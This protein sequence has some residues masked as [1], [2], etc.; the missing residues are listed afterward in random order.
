L[1]IFV[2]SVSSVTILALT[3]PSVSGNDDVTL[4]VRQS[5]KREV[6]FDPGAAEESEDDV[7]FFD[8]DTGK[9]DHLLAKKLAADSTK[10]NLGEKP[11]A[12][13]A[14]P[15]PNFEEEP[16][17]EM[18][19]VPP[20][21]P[22][23][24]AREPGREQEGRWLPEAKGNQPE[25]E[26]AENMHEQSV[27]VVGTNTRDEEEEPTLPPV[28]LDKE[29]DQTQASDED[30]VGPSMDFV[31][32]A[33]R[34]LAEKELTDSELKRLSPKIALM[35]IL[36]NDLPPRHD[37]QQT[38][39]NVRYILENEP[40]FPNTRKVWVFNRI[41]SEEKIA[42]LR[43]LIEA[44]PG[45]EILTIPFRPDDYARQDYDFNS[46][47]TPNYVFVKGWSKIGT[48]DQYYHHKNLYIINNNG[49][50][51]FALAQGKLGG[52]T[53]ILPFDGNS[54]F[55]LTN[56]KHLVRDLG[57]SD[58]T[59]YLVIPMVRVGG[60]NSN[61]AALAK[62]DLESYEEPQ[63]AFR[64]DATEVF[65]E[66]LRY[67]RR[68]KIELLNRIGMWN[69]GTWKLLPWEDPWVQN[70]EAA[71]HATISTTWVA[72]L[73]SGTNSTLESDMASRGSS[74]SRGIRT[75][76][77]S[78]DV[79]RALTA[80]NVSQP[81][82][83]HLDVLVKQRRVIA[84]GTAS[85]GLGAVVRALREEAD[86][87][88]PVLKSPKLTVP[89]DRLPAAVQQRLQNITILTL[90]SFFFDKKRE[91]D[92]FGMVAAAALTSLTSSSSP[93][94]PEPVVGKPLSGALLKSIDLHYA[95][96]ALKIMEITGAMTP[97]QSLVV[98]GWLEKYHA[99]AEGKQKEFFYDLHTPST[100]FHLQQ[101]VLASLAN[102]TKG[103]LWKASFAKA[104][105]LAHASGRGPEGD[106]DSFV[107]NLQCYV[108]L[109]K[110]GQAV[111]V[112]LWGYRP[113]KWR[114]FAPRIE[115]EKAGAA[116]RKALL[117]D[118]LDI[119]QTELGLYRL[120]TKAAVENSHL[121]LM[122][123][124]ATNH[125]KSVDSPK[126]RR[127]KLT[128]LVPGAACVRPFWALGT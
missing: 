34:N 67:G 93:F 70:P 78:L 17:S 45:H 71:A 12:R 16:V 83:Y 68:P 38:L 116:K 8:L 92:S 85:E 121:D 24:T 50:R 40:N 99:W 31:R 73:S 115:K 58:S 62:Q 95:V 53:W 46:F 77:N 84:A 86:K 2:V 91:P 106:W 96:D 4:Q 80:W 63:V 25:Q 48:Y 124:L 7:D 112:D 65:D 105:L 75:I 79:A 98:R 14:D 101:G 47:H 125:T 89:A 35:R 43:R 36:G 1:A 123:T 59:H 107:T 109:A 76:A 122:I 22:A 60:S 69:M 39:N 6:E 32:P 94:S 114:V 5:P 29:P 33:A 100:V 104:R 9:Q 110:M 81:L 3:G 120:H 61:L 72:R 55:P 90:A 103:F 74:R 20:S 108:E 54:F 126:D 66:T 117:Q 10:V 111:N 56:W 44:H 97:E 82:F 27:P 15:I 119:L 30:P 127:F 41:I 19:E 18:D 128:Q 21:P 11:A 118:R 28:A 64:K 49:A 23:A 51:N 88:M 113:E 102:D 26:F 52:A 57:R 37:A 13:A 42:E 87:I